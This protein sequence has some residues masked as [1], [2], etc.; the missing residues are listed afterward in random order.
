[1]FVWKDE[2]KWKRVRDG[3]VFLKKLKIVILDPSTQFDCLNLNVDYTEE[4]LRL[5]EYRETNFPIE[6]GNFI[7]IGGKSIWWTL[8]QV[9]P[10]ANTFVKKDA[11]YVLYLIMTLNNYGRSCLITWA[12]DGA[13]RKVINGLFK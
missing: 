2:N 9:I 1:M 3:P 10:K 7:T 11:S 4:P 12:T 6:S 13:I 5:T 8:A